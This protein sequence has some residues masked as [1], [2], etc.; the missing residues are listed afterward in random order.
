MRRILLFDRFGS[1]LGE[2][3]TND[4]IACERR[5]EI[6]GEHSLTI[7]TT[8][9]LTKGSRVVYEDGR[10]V[11]REYAVI[12]VDEE[13]TTGKKPIGTYY[14]VWSIQPDLQGVTV[15]VMPGVQTP[16]TASTALTSLLS[17]QSRWQRG[18][19]TNTATGGA[20]MYDR[21]AWQALG[22]LVSVWGGEVSTHLDV[23][24]LTGVT[25]RYVDLY[26][27]MGEATALRRFD[28]GADLRSIKRVQDDSTYYCRL[29]PRGAGEETDA[30]GYGR[31]IT[32]ESVNSGKDYLEYSP[33]VDV[34]KLPDGNG[35][36]Q[37]PT[38]I[39][40]N[41]D[42]ETPA[43]L[44]AWAQSILADTLTPKITYEIDA[45]QAAIEGV[46]VQGVSLGD[47]VQVVDRNFG[48]NGIRLT[49]RVTA[50]TVD[51]LNERNVSI[52]LGE[53]AKTL[54][55]QFASLST[56]VAS[57]SNTITT[58]ST[59][60]YIGNLVDRIN[61]EV[62]ATGGYT[63]IVPGNGMLT[64]D[65]AVSDPLVGSEASQVTEIKG[66]TIRIA[67]SRTAQGAWD[68]K[69]VFISGH[70][71]AELVTA[72]NITAGYVSADVITGGVLVVHDP[73]NNV[74]IFRADVTNHTTT[75][76]GFTVDAT[77][78]YGTGVKLTGSKVQFL[79]SGNVIG[80]MRANSQTVTID[81]ETEFAIG[82]TDTD[83]NAG[84][85]TYRQ[86][87][88]YSKATDAF[89][90]YSPI[91]N[92][93]FSSGCTFA[94]DGTNN[95][96]GLLVG[97]NSIY[98]GRNSHSSTS[99]G[100]RMDLQGLSTCYS[101]N[102]NVGQYLAT[103][104]SL[105]YVNGSSVVERA[106]LTTTQLNFYN[107]SGTANVELDAS[108]GLLRFL[109]SGTTHGY[110]LCTGS[111]SARNLRVAAPKNIIFV[112]DGIALADSFADY[113]DGS[114][115]YSGGTGY[116]YYKDHSGTNKTLQVLHGII[117]SVL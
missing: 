102:A 77:S 95:L 30:G 111:S 46:D 70:I 13:H 73:V 60:E 81:L 101:I 35:G 94:G 79:Q 23:S 89:S 31:K 110:L 47:A 56:Q 49:A 39:V 36:Y 106:K 40:E 18:T 64:Y 54:A 85:S 75:I 82:T 14:C 55:S 62:N 7:A 98:N 86:L 45:A 43:E 19:V 113:D 99:I 87:M 107:S 76:G 72:A 48:D 90:F 69:T 20:S 50:M 8:Q 29:S 33:M 25:A 96:G 66:G 91:K 97:Y 38:L 27:Q 104:M 116:V 61:T 15:S 37:Y 58:M 78:L 74:D 100:A 71:A 51:E 2:L 5:E 65:A 21:S 3:S 108:T 105:G 114:T 103:K 93:T 52:T 63:Y 53:V 57:I 68:W 6:N 117:V 112:S 16:A 17:T 28:F 83:A 80:S 11:W 1:P 44:L 67:N 34:A 84:T 26:A 9:A 115:L 92:T 4:V 22:T 88:L 10:G 59:S 32:I 109:T 41:S 24:T 12:G 42:C